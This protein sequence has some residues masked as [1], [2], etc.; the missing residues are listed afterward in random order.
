M[1]AVS[2][3]WFDKEENIIFLEFAGKWTEAEFRTAYTQIIAMMDRAQQKIHFIVNMQ[4]SEHI[5]PKAINWLIRA[6][7]YG[8]P[9]MGIAVYVGLNKF[10]QAI[11]D[12]AIA[13]FPEALEKYPVEF[14]KTIAEAEAKLYHH[15]GD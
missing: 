15:R 8:H 13:L 12:T 6:A 14:A 3:K 1:M 5:P 9:N 7:N 2:V 11:A 10:M 4:P